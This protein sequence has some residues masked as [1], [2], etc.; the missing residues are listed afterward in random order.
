MTTPVYNVINGTDGDDL[1]SAT[2]QSSTNNTDPWWRHAVIY[3]IYPQ[4]FQDSDGDG[5]GDLK[6]ITSRL[7]YLR[8]LGIDA[9]WITPIYPSPGVDNGYDIA[10]Y[11][12]IDPKYGSLADFDTLEAEAKKRGITPNMEQFIRS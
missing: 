8:N 6:G 2:A 12:A 5:V 3:E 7:D 10:D 9:I 4:S 11:T 1:L